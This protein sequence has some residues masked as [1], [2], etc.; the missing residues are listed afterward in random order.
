MKRLAILIVTYL[1]LFMTACPSQAQL[2]LPNGYK[3]D[4][5]K[6]NFLAS[7]A[8][9][10]VETRPDSTLLLAEQG[11][12]LARKSN[13]KNG[14]ARCLLEL[15]RGFRFLGNFIKAI[16]LFQQSLK[17]SEDDGDV[18]GQIRA[19]N[20]YAFIYYLQEDYHKE[21]SLYLQAIKKAKTFADSGNIIYPLTNAGQ[22]YISLNKL[23][24]ANF[25]LQKAF[26]LVE[27]LQLIDTKAAFLYRTYGNFKTAR[28]EKD[29]ALFYYRKSASIYSTQNNNFRLAELNFQIADIYQK[30]N[31]TDSALQ[32]AQQSFS[33]AE[34]SPNPAFMISKP[35]FLLAKLYEGTNNYKE[36]FQF[37]KIAIA[38]KDSVLNK[39]KLNQLSNLLYSEQL[40]KQEL[41]AA[42]LQYQNE[43]R[44]YV[45]I[46]IT[47]V[48]LLIAFMLY[49]NNRHKHK[50]NLLL[51]Q[52]NTEI[53]KQS[54]KTA[55]ALTRLKATQAQLIQ[56]EKMASLG[57]LTAGIAHEIQ[58]PL[59]FVN[60][61]SETN[62]ELL[63][64]LK[65]EIS[66]DNKEGALSLADDL[67]QNEQKIVH[68]G[69]RADSIVKGMLQH[70]RQTT[71]QKEPTDINQLAD[72]YLRLSYQAMRSKDKTFQAVIE[73]HFDKSIDKISIVPQDIGRVLL[74]L[75]NNA[76]YAVQEKK[77]R[78]NRVYEPIVKVCTRKERSFVVITVKGNGTGIPEK[79]KEKIYQPFFTTKPT[80][81]GTGLGLSLSYDIITK[82]HGGELKVKTKEGEGAEFII[83]LPVQ[84]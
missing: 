1:L 13:Y 54:A 57:E 18:E 29:S 41:A 34:Q 22:S 67:I 77:Q 70:S 23:D 33:L 48:F 14:E 56:S 27:R 11:L 78:L 76:F 38:A 44:I 51:Q 47:G 31:K 65:G 26:R 66:A 53:E 8:S 64:D 69:K 30:D 5:A 25:Y 74:N 19:L 80:G 3:S 7:R 72:E 60:N 10:Y 43:T 2:N 61:F 4:T 32:Y 52:K 9:D 62:V 59:N 24:S 16:Q 6:V 21:V 50:A 73:M 71:G 42:R 84:S 79:V 58:N 40:Q 68:H 20:S 49:R 75:F 83:Q 35:S 63:T 45:F 46:S 55:A 37:Y 82:G 12:G 39:E 17:I 15:G 81:E 28:Q 36:A